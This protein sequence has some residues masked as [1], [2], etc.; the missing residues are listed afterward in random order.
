MV[1][2]G[3]LQVVTSVSSGLSIVGSL[4][5]VR[6]FAK[7]SDRHFNKLLLCILSVLNFLATVAFGG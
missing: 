5:V 1:S 2:A 4:Y 6:C 3:F 7:S